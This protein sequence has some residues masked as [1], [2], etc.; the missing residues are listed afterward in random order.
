L[1]AASG[2]G[3]RRK[4][5]PDFRGR[6][7]RVTIAVKKKRNAADEIAILEGQGG[8]E[9]AGQ[10]LQKRKLRERRGSTALKY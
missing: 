6:R 5:D 4:R 7:G 10:Q 9:G 2:K 1:D 8:M 3:E